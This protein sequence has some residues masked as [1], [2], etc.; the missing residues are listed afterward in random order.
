[1]RNLWNAIALL[2]IG[3]LLTHP[4]GV[5]AQAVDPVEVVRN[6]IATANTGDFDKTFAFYAEGAVVK[7][8]VGLFVGR[9]AIGDWLRQDVQTT[10]A[11]PDK[12]QVVNGSTVINTGMV[13]LARFEQLGLGQTQYRAEYIIE[14]DKIKYFSPSPILS[15]EQQEKLRAATPVIAPPA[16]DPIEVVRNYIATA[17]TG[18]FDKTFAFYA[19]GAVVRNAVGLFVGRDAIGDWLRQDV[20]T[21]RATPQEFQVLNGSTVINTGM[22]SLARFEQLGLGQ[23]QYRAEYIIEGDKIKYFSPSPILTPEQQAKLQ[24]AAQPGA[25]AA[26]PRTGTGAGEGGWV[27][28]LALLLIASGVGLI[29][30]RRMRRM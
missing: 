29:T 2:I 16:I 11:T 3:V 13:S 19:E 10:R 18:D 4:A 26:L 23:T 14:G 8:A 12:F 27:A 20:Q 6:Y 28:G 22:V 21:T 25:P 15:P 9:D 24:A 7:N 1:M 30:R 17:N 5:S